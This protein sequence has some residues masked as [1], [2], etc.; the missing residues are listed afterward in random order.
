MVGDDP[1]RGLGLAFGGNP[2]LVDDG[3]DQ[4]PEQV[5]LVIVVGA[6]Q[7]GGDALKAHA[8]IDR[9]P[10]QTD[11]F[12]LRDLLELHE[13]EVPDFDETVTVGI[14]GTGRSTRN[15]V[16]MIEED[17]RTRAARAGIA[18]RPEIVR[19]RDADDAAVGNPGDLLPQG[20]GFVVLGIDRDG[21]LVLGQA[22]LAGDQRPGPFDGVGFEIIAKREVAEHLEEGVMARRIADIVEVIVLAAGADAFLR[23]G[24][25]A[26]GALL[27]TGED[28]LELHHAGIGEHQGGIVARY[29]RR[30]G[31]NLMALTPEEVEE[32]G[33]DLREACHGTSGN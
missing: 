29:Q 21:E 1:V 3:A 13:D 27:N 24:G 5:G 14:H 31:H 8:G 4:R 11:A 23:R 25:A 16:A 19:G 32:G 22:Q 2:G 15:F 28:I 6:L 12:I 26:V 30:G 18:H 7:H 9:R 17:F 20:V 33:T 10:R